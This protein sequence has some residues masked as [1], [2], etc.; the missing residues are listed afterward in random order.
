[1]SRV[2]A[3]VRHLT[4]GF[5]GKNLASTTIVSVTAR[6]ALPT[7]S[8][9]LPSAEADAANIIDASCVLEDTLGLLYAHHGVLELPFFLFEGNAWAP[10]CRE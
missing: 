4:E 2:T 9:S 5:L 7:A 10:R 1:M 8:G 6:S 3:S